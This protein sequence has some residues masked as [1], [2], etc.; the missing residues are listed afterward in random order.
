[1]D[2]QQVNRYN[3][4][5]VKHVNYIF[6]IVTILGMLITLVFSAVAYVIVDFIGYNS[7][8][9]IF[10]YLSSPFIQVV[11]IFL[12]VF[13]YL[14]FIEADYKKILRLN[15]LRL[16]Y[17]TPLVILGIASQFAGMFLKNISIFLLQFLGRVPVME[18][19]PPTSIFELVYMLLIVAVAPA[20]FEEIFARG[21]I[22]RAYEKFGAKT[23]IVVSSV[24]FGIMHYDITNFIFPIFLGL[25]L[26]Y[27]VYRTNSI[28]AGMIVHFVNNAL[29]VVFL[30]I[31]KPLQGKYYETIDIADILFYFIIAVIASVF[32]FCIIHYI[33]Q[34][35]KFEVQISETEEV[36]TIDESP[37]KFTFLLPI[38]ISIAILLISFKSTIDQII[39][40]ISTG[41]I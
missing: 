18:I 19:L 23:G 15:K 22:M 8:D 40:N 34:T 24:F 30:Y 9:K 7:P 28:F 17:V 33:Y 14:L 5:N 41:S 11:G 12:P 29:G 16:K 36:V 37:L 10:L 35:T 31:F 3:K 26:G 38:L 2:N 1:M 6:L 39:C 25:I 4:I 13:F 27:V 32:I 20:I 21:L